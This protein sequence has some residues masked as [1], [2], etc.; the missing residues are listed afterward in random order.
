MIWEEAAQRE[1]NI[2]EI[3]CSFTENESN[4]VFVDGILFIRFQI[5]EMTYFKNTLLGTY[6]FFYLNSIT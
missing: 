6:N 3:A 1:M 5:N 2:F 4:N